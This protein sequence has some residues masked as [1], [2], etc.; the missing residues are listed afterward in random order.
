MTWFNS[1]PTS[2]VFSDT[3]QPTMPEIAAMN[4]R[5]STVTACGNSICQ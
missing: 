4:S 1:K 5:R 3:G 2:A